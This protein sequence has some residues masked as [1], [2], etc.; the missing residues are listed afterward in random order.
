MAPGRTAR[1]RGEIPGSRGDAK[2]VSRRGRASKELRNTGIDILGDMLW[3]SHF[4]LFYETKQDLFDTLVPYF[5]TGLE[6][7]EF[8][9]WVVSGPLTLDEARDALRQGV[10]DFDRYLAK[11]SIE[12]FPGREWYLKENEFGLKRIIDGW[13][14]KL[15]HALNHGFEGMRA[16]AN[17][18]WLATKHY[19]DFCAYEHEVNGWFAGNPLAVLCTYPLTASKASDM[20]DVA[21]AH[22]FTFARRKGDWE[23]IES[24]ERGHAKSNGPLTEREREVLAWVAQGKSAWEIGKILNIAKRTVDEYAATAYRKLGAVNRAQAVAIAIRD[25]L[26]GGRK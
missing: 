23:V 6:S 9:F 7:N 11:G 12:F 15:Q 10:P 18:F 20:L 19:E 14:E 26:I 25:R 22:Q 5:K 17:A 2:S 3:G 1:P 21:R 16:S 24:P 4:C 8:C 13:M